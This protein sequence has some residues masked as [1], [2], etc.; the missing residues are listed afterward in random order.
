MTLRPAGRRDR[1]AVAAGAEQISPAT[2]AASGSDLGGTFVRL[3]PLRI[4]DAALTLRWRQTERAA[5]LNRGAQT[6]AAQQAWIAARPA[7]EYNFIIEL[8]DSG[9]PVGML[10]LIDIDLVHRRAEPGRFLIGEP[11]A[12][13]GIPAAVEAMKLLYELAFDRLALVRVCGTVAADNTLM[14]KWQKYLGMKEE[15]RLRAHYFLDG[16]FQDAVCL[17]LLAEEYRT[18]TVPRMRALIAAGRRAAAGSTA[19]TETQ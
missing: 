17:G 5:F 10:S 12:V 7:A 6:L 18:V 1:P 14:I 2:A 15:G 16:R 8:V 13:K 19:S 3:R 11:D 9:R 4:A